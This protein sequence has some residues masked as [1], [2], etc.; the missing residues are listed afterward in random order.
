MTNFATLEQLQQALQ[1]RGIVSNIKEELF[2]SIA[3]PLLGA[4]IQDDKKRWYFQLPNTRIYLGQGANPAAL[5]GLILIIS[6]AKATL[7][8]AE[9]PTGKWEIATVR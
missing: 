1:T 5:Q 9:N 6:G 3:L 4:M 2:G 7:I 8:T